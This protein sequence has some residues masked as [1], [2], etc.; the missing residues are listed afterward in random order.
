MY[1]ILNDEEYTE[2][3]RLKD[4]MYS[5]LATIKQKRYELMDTAHFWKKNVTKKMLG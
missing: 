2:Y 1:H 3:K 4:G 5:C